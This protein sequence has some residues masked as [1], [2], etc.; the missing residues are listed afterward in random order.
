M[1]NLLHWFRNAGYGWSGRPEAPYLNCEPLGLVCIVQGNNWACPEK[2]DMGAR[3]TFEFREPLEFVKSMR[4]LGLSGC[5]D[6]PDVTVFFDQ[7]KQI[8]MDTPVTGENSV[9]T[10]PFKTNLYKNVTRIETNTNGNGVVSSLEFPSCAKPLKPLIAVKKYVGPPDLCTSAGVT[11]MEDNLYSLPDASASWAYCYV[12]SIPSNSEEC[13]YENVT[14]IDIQIFGPGAINSLEYPYCAQSP[15]TAVSIKKYAGPPNLCTASGITSMQDDVYTLSATNLTWAYCY[16]I[17]VPDTSEECLYDVT[18]TDRAPI[19][20]IK[21]MR[22]VTAVRETLCKGQTKYIPGVQRTGLAAHEG[23]FDA[24]VQGYGYYSGTEVTS[25]DH[26]SVWPPIP[27]T[28]QP[29][30][31]PSSSRPTP[32]PMIKLDFNNLQNPMARYYGQDSTFR[33][34]DYVFDQLWWTH[35]VKISAAGAGWSFGSLFIPKFTRGLGWNNSKPT[36]EYFSCQGRSYPLVR[37]DA[38]QWKFR[39]KVQPT[40]LRVGGR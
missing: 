6:T 8:T 38:S 16:V 22:N 34:G 26:A 33:A 30:P 19:G 11:N 27:P 21:G 9:Y 7:G 13:L 25:R 32:C 31:A 18:L 17:T 29:T 4:F 39:L 10:L 36:R 14:R 5:G 1:N 2:T 20:G 24:I 28:L 37:Y 15:A 40:T 12:V 23:P 35:G 3:I